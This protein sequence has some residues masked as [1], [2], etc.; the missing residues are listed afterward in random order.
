MRHPGREFAS[1]A[2]NRDLNRQAIGGLLITG[3]LM[4]IENFDIRKRQ[5]MRAQHRLKLVLRYP[6]AM[7]RIA[8]ITLGRALKRVFKAMDEM[9]AQARDV[10]DV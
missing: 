3:E 10:Q 7:F 9:I 1:F 6:L 2:V 4:A 8:L 5:G